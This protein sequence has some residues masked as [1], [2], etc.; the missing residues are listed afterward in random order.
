[1]TLAE[2]IAGL[3]AS[4]EAQGFTDLGKIFS[5]PLV[6]SDNE[7]VNGAQIIEDTNSKGDFVIALSDCI[8]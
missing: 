8:R 6:L 5:M 4:Q 3:L 1:M 2:L 7:E